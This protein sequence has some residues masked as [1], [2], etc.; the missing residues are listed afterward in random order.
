MYIL[1]AD[2]DTAVSGKIKHLLEKNVK[3]A[4]IIISQTDAQ[5]VMEKVEEYA[6]ALLIIGINLRGLNGLEIMK[7]LRHIGN[8]LEVILISPYSYFE[9]VRAA[10][11][12]GARDY[13]LVPAIETQLLESAMEALRHYEEK[14][15]EIAKAEER[16]Q[17]MEEARRHV[18]YSLIYAALFNGEASEEI[19]NYRKMFDLGDKGYILNV[20]ID[21]FETDSLIDLKK[22]DDRINNYL[23]QIVLEHNNCIIGP[24]TLNRILIWIDSSDKGRRKPESQMEDIRL[25][26]H[27]LIGLKERF[28]IN[29]SIGIGGE[30]SIFNIH[31]SYEEAVRCL[32]YKGRHNIMRIR[33]VE[34]NDLSQEKYID[35]ESR[36][37][38]SIKFG[39]AEIINLFVEFLDQIRCLEEDAE[40][41]KIYEIL[42]LASHQARLAGQNETDYVNI[43]EFVDEIWGLPMEKIERWAY[44]K[45]EFIINSV[46][47]S[48][49]EIRSD[50][51]NSAI[52]YMEE[53]YMEEIT[54]EELARY[55]GLSPQ[56]FSKIF[57]DDIGLNY[58]EWL[59]RLRI[60]V[61]KR[62][63]SDG[64]MSVKEVCYLVGYNDPNYFSRIFRKTEGMSPS[65]YAKENI[66]NSNN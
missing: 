60:D 43:R 24:R 66:P 47:T 64:G 56:H 9:F 10:M 6:P 22:D 12:A 63:L 41:N 58:I 65:A 5:D 14:K 32:R 15:E 23:R 52:R 11:K 4:R 1:V 27:I 17:S 54:L 49:T 39:K 40:R 33:D 46:Q 45:F 8:P 25:A 26:A 62:L 51:V 34:K 7:Q 59:T 55:I 61:A 19:K 42:V 21:S 44:R 20:E 2:S 29:V 57:K 37:L 31:S 48:R 3:G 35:I 53:H 16:R 38:K 36:L 30:S 18:E 13:I 50:A 28:L